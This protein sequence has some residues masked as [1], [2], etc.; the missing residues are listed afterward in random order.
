MLSTSMEIS[1][2]S[3]CVPSWREGVPYACM[4]GDIEITA[5]LTVKE[6][7]RGAI[8]FARWNAFPSSPDEARARKDNDAGTRE[9]VEAIARVRSVRSV[10]PEA[11]E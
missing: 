1:L 2:S 9:P 5:R 10:L 8:T 3:S 11:V 6:P 7:D 4:R